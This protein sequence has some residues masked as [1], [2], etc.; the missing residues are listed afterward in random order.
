MIATFTLCDCHLFD[1]G[2]VGHQPI[3]VTTRTSS[4][5]HREATSQARSRSSQWRERDRSGTRRASHRPPSLSWVP[6]PTS[7]NREIVLLVVIDNNG[8]DNDNHKEVGKIMQMC[9]ES[10]VIKN[11]GSDD[12]S[13][14]D[15][16]DIMLIMMMVMKVMM[17]T[18]IM[19]IMTMVMMIMIMLMT[20][21]MMMITITLMTMMMMMITIMLM[22]MV[23]MMITITLMTMMMQGGPQPEILACRSVGLLQVEG[24]TETPHSPY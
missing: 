2:K 20:M 13:Y 24:N 3:T 10:K 8:I 23:M 16:D 9:R 4:R 21:V 11:S 14:D 5:H 6:R 15:D 1:R 22:T 19:L 17:M 18:M 7:E 12:N